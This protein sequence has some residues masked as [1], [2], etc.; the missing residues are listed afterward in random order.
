MVNTEEYLKMPRRT[1]TLSNY[2]TLTLA[3]NTEIP[4]TRRGEKGTPISS[5]LPFS[6]RLQ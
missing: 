2:L 3:H 5:V 6:S 1:N 4:R